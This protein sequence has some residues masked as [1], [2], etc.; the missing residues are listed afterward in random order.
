MWIP[1]L[2]F[3]LLLGGWVLLLALPARWRV[4]GGWTAV[5]IPVLCLLLWLPLRSQLPVVATRTAV[6]LPPF[7]WQIDAI[8]WPLTLWLLLLLTAA[9][10]VSSLGEA[11]G[12]K[13]SGNGQTSLPPASP[14]HPLTPSL[15]HLLIIAAF[16]LPAVWAGSA[17]TMMA[18]WM[19]L[20]VVWGTAVWLAERGETARRRFFWQMGL[21]LT[22]VL[23]LWFGA[24]A[25]DTVGWNAAAW[26]Q[27]ALL[28]ALLAALLPLGVWPLSGW[29]ASA[30]TPSAVA[31]VLS[32][33]PVA[34]GGVLLVRL[35]EGA[36]LTVWMG[37]MLLTLAGL[38]GLLQ[39][40]RR[41]WER[42]HLPGMAV[43]FLT[44]SLVHLL[45]LTAVWGNQTSASPHGV[46]ALLRVLLLA[47]GIFY[48]AAGRPVTRRMWW[49]MIPPLIALA[50]VA[51][52]PLTA[53][54]AGQVALIEGLVGHG[55]Y[56]AL[57][58]VL[59]LQIPL[60]TAGLRLFWP[61]VGGD[62]A[63]PDT[64]AAWATEAALFLPVLGLVSVSGIE[65]GAVSWFTWLLL[66]LV[67]VGSVLLL[68]FVPEFNRT[69]AAVRQAFTFRLPFN[70]APLRQWLRGMGGAFEEAAAILE[71][72]GSLVWL[73]ILIVILLFVQ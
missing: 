40:V 45:L 28:A 17:A 31:L 34:A 48:L 29:R 18:S 12:R 44:V 3:C 71:G 32:L 13:D 30:G 16:I 55:R 42:L 72:D 47:G 52:L 33:W 21:L 35:A 51:G 27:T 7:V 6:P 20:L 61:T 38:F 23:L 14:L 66:L 69:V 15:A 37:G 73:L 54:L 19:A 8:S 65:W 46:F 24:A 56:L 2:I 22:A 43:Y 10:T 60:L 5:A 26:P 62:E 68:R 4:Y 59:L 11:G 67:P 39:G 9:L 25:A 64:P 57:L 58:V 1:V 63:L 36:S 41:L 49:R 53:G 70:S 50:A